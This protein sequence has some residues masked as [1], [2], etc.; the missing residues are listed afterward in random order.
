MYHNIKYFCIKRFVYH[1]LEEKQKV[2]SVYKN[3]DSIPLA[4]LEL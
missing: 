1:I 2:M 4:G 3:L